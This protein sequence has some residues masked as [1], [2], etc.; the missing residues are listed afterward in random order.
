M[1]VA[2]LPALTFLAIGV[3]GGSALATPEDY[4]AAYAVDFANAGSD[5]QAIWQK[6]FDNAGKD[7]LL[8]Y[9][10]P[11]V[12][13]PAVAAKVKQPAKVAIVA[14][15]KPKP[16]PKP[17]QVVTP[18]GIKTKDVKKVAVAEVKVAAETRKP[19]PGTPAWIDYCTRKYV[20]FNPAKGTYLSKTGLE[21]KCLVTNDFK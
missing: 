10:T 16:L 14:K 9:A 8:Q 7:C 2:Y 18:A 15:V 12:I 5:D 1:R 21:R 6:R 3:L 11:T 4:C 17:K 20:S 13:P 19:E